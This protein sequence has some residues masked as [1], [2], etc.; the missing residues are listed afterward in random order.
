MRISGFIEKYFW[1]FLIAGIFIGLLDPMPFKI[2]P[3]FLPKMLLGM[4]L[5]LVFL[6]IDSLQV[7]ENI[8]N[9]KLMIYISFFYM[10]IIP[11][12][13]FFSINFFN[14]ELAIGIL[15]LTAMPAGVSTPALTDIVKGNVPLSLSLAIVSQI[16][17][18]FT[19]PLLFWLIDLNSH[20]IDKLLMLKDM[21]IIV[22]L[23]MIISQVIKKH[24]PLIIKKTQHL[25]TS[26]NVLLLFTFVCLAISSQ[27]NTILEN[28]VGLVWKIAVLYLVFIML[29]VIG[30]LI[31]FKQNKENRVAVA[32][33]AAYMNNGMAIV[34]AASYFKPEILVLM[35]LSE[36]PWNTLLA[37][38]KRVIRQLK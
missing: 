37:P 26:L 13:F 29:H 6:K 32:I 33:G 16:V 34:L 4:M 7:L 28:P 31:C 22:F 1:L 10:F 3:A 12:F 18:P 36:L 25:F 11:F 35:V 24:F 19:V 27:R 38:F 8:R 20:S 5:F 23:P 30:Y 2:F 17:A 9:Y 15:L 14:P 21:A